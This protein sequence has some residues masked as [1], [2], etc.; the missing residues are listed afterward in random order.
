ISEDEQWLW[1]LV[2]EAERVAA[3]APPKPD[4]NRL[5]EVEQSYTSI[6]NLEERVLNRIRLTEAALARPA[7]WLR[8]AH[9]AAIVRHLREDRSTAVATAVQR[10]RVEEA[11]A[12][13]R[14][15]ANAHASYL[16]QHHAVLAAGRNARMEL[17]RIFDDLIDGY[18][19]LAEPPAWFRFGLGFPPPPG[20]QP[21]WLVQARQ[22]LAQRRR[23]ALEQPIL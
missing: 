4:P 15:I 14:S 16:A 17:E 23:L 19:R 22:V 11:L 2:D 18:A 10:G 12:K 13:L 9:R 5:A 7:S 3:A 6:R 20:A 1:R 8:P 21:Q